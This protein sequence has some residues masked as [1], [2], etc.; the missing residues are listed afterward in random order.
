LELCLGN[1]KQLLESTVTGDESWSF[2]II[3][4]QKGI[5]GMMQTRRSTAENGQGHSIRQESH[6]NDLLG[7]QRNFVD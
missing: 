1:Q 7:L 2:I 4:Y 6:G 5:N 3:L